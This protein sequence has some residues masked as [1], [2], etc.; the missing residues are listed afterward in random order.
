MY[1]VELTDV[2]YDSWDT[3]EYVTAFQRSDWIYCGLTHGINI[4][5]IY[6]PQDIAIFDNLIGSLLILEAR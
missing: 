5:I 3:A 6:S 1:A 2:E 4:I